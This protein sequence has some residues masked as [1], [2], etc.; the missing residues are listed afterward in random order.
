VSR[1]FTAP[2]L[3]A[4]ALSIAAVIVAIR[5][6]KFTNVLIGAAVAT[7]TVVAMSVVLERRVFD[8]YEQGRR[9]ERRALAR[10]LDDRTPRG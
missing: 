6:E 4:A 7:S 9:A 5:F 1:L 8:A 10:K 3:I 2:V